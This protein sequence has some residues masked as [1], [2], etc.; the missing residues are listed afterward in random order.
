M[1]KK[2]K[3]SGKEINKSNGQGK[4]VNRRE[5]K[6]KQ[7]KEIRSSLKRTKRT[8]RCRQKQLNGSQLKSRD[9]AGRET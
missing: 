2:N 8:E 9:R 7:S 4:V 5:T 1:R 6:T 3:K